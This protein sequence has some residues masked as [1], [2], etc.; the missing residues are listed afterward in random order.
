VA[1]LGPVKNVPGVENYD[2]TGLVKSHAQ[3]PEMMPDILAFIG[4]DA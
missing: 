1:G 4:F 2:V 3:Y